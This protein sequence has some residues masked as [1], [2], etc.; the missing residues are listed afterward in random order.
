[1][2]VPVRNASK[3]LEGGILYFIALEWSKFIRLSN[4][5][6]AIRMISEKVSALKLFQHPRPGPIGMILQR[7]NVLHSLKTVYTHTGMPCQYGCGSVFR[8]TEREG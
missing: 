8:K 1:M 3:A 6:E 2:S 5:F 7:A 4:T